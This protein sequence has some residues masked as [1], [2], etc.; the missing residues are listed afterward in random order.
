MAGFDHKGSVKRAI[1]F[2]AGI[3]SWDQFFGTRSSAYAAC[4][5]NVI[6]LIKRYCEG[7]RLHSPEQLNDEGKGILAFKGRCGLRAYFWQCTNTK[8][9]QLCVIGLVV[10]KKT[11]KLD[12]AHRE[13]TVAQ[14]VLFENMEQM[15]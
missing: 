13:K 4:Q 14:R 3:D 12:P 15:R 10:H 11:R 1:T 7:H 2:G 6:A 9:E 8:G 5:A